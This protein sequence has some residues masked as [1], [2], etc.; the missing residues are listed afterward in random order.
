MNLTMGPHNP[1]I[2]A[3]K[4]FHLSIILGKLSKSNCGI[5][6]KYHQAAFNFVETAVDKMVLTLGVIHEIMTH[7]H[8][9]THW[10]HKTLGP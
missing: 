2:N 3:I 10:Y 6:K 9:A 7:C 5:L 4:R 8:A 1:F